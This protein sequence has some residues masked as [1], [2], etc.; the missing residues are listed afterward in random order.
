MTAIVTKE[1]TPY[2]ADVKKKEIYTIPI[3]TL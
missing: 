3:I 1:L 2:I